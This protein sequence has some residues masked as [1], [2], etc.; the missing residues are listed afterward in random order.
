M[1][2]DVPPGEA[3]G[4]YQWTG[5]PTWHAFREVRVDNRTGMAL[6][7]GLFQEPDGVVV[8]QIAPAGWAPPQPPQKGL[9]MWLRRKGLWPGRRDGG[10]GG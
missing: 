3:R 9:A 5:R 1:S 2:A 10:V 7:V 6:E 4:I 8:M